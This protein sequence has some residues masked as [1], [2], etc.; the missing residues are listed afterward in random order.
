MNNTTI[1]DPPRGLKAIPWRLPIWLYRLKLG[2]MLGH[3]LLLLHHIGRVSGLP[4]QAVL[5]VVK[6]DKETNTH[7]VASGFGEK[8][9]WFLNIMASPEVTIQV[10]GIEFPVRGERLNPQDAESIF[11]DYHQRNPKALQGLSKLIGYEISDNQT[12]MLEFFTKEIPVI[13][14]RPT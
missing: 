11:A 2:R 8:A 9:D 7:F 4:R 3:R 14:L 1:P 5:E 12:E 6:F 13:A 10:A